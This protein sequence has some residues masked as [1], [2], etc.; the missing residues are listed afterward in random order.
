MI[1]AIQEAK[2]LNKLILNNLISSLMSPEMKLIGDEPTK[3][4]KSI[5]LNSKGK[6]VKALQVVESE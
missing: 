2:D 1:T 6:A 4:S 3:K 5:A